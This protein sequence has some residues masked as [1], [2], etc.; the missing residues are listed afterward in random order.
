[1]HIIDVISYYYLGLLNKG[2]ISTSFIFFYFFCAIDRQ[3]GSHGTAT[4]ENA[5]SVTDRREMYSSGSYLF[6]A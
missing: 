3:I 1:M 5:M 6:C 4:S 2:V